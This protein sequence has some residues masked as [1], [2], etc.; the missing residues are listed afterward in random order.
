M[1]TLGGPRWLRRFGV[2]LVILSLAHVPLPLADF[3]VIAHADGEG[4]I[5]PLHN[6]LLK[7]H[8]ATKAS[9]SPV[10][11]F[12]WAFLTRPVPPSDADGPAVHADAPDP[13]DFELIGDGATARVKTPICSASGCDWSVIL[14]ALQ[15]PTAVI[16]NSP[17]PRSESAP[18]WRNFAASF[19]PH[20]F[21]TCRLQRWVC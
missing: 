12:H 1:R 10:L 21:T 13:F 7:W 20:L 14:T 16:G 19:P 15:A 11:H 8:A 9:A 17:L 18:I 5:C 4:Q 3:H 6:H 2:T